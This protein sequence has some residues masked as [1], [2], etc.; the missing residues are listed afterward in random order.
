MSL[1]PQSTPNAPSE[2]IWVDTHAHLDAGEFDGR[3]AVAAERARLVGVACGVIPAVEKAN[4][5][6]VQTLARA[7]GWAYALGIHPL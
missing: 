3:G 4:F 2:P 1:A 6:T 7:S 5:A